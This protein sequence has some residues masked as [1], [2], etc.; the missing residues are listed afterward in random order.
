M[1]HWFIWVNTC[2]TGPKILFNVA[3]NIYLNVLSIFL[4]A[5]SLTSYFYYNQEIS[6]EK[7]SW[8][9]QYI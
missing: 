1:V 8:F 5:Q 3:W 4:K 6:E 9:K 7:V 2:I